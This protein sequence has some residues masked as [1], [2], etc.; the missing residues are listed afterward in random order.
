MNSFHEILEHTTPMKHTHWH[1]STA[2]YTYTTCS[3]ISFTVIDFLEDSSKQKYTFEIKVWMCTLIMGGIFRHILL[4]SIIGCGGPASELKKGWWEWWILLRFA[5]H[6]SL[7]VIPSP[8]DTQWLWRIPSVPMGTVWKSFWVLLA[9]T[10]FFLSTTCILDILKSIYEVKNS[11][12][13]KLS[14]LKF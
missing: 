14:G 10:T 1:N 4:G 9:V 13:S 3:L 8:T 7:F 12:N 11:H 6:F 5:C 2:P